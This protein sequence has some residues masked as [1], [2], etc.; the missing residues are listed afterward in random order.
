MRLHCPKDPVPRPGEPLR[1][2]AWRPYVSPSRRV[3]AW[4]RVR[5]VL[6]MLLL[7]AYLAWPF[8]LLSI[9]LWK[10]LR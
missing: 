9:V 6:F 1:A 8:V 5:A 4:R 10:V 7:Y 2:G 3:R